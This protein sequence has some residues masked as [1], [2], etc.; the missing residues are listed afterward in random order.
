MKYAFTFVLAFSFPHIS[1]AT[2]APTLLQV[3]ATQS[4]HLIHFTIINMSGKPREAHIRD[5][6]VHLPVAEPVALQVP[7]GDSVKIT[8]N[9]NRG[10]MRVITISATDEGHLLPID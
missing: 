1:P 3:R 4:R 8:S 6:V 10:V 5:S 9:T 7:L 2:P